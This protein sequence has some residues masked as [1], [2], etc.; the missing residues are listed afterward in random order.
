[1]IFTL[2]GCAPGERCLIERTEEG[3][4]THDDTVAANDWC[5]SDPAW[6]AR[7]GAD[8]LLSATFEQAEA[9]S[10]TR[11]EALARWS[12]RLPTSAFEW[13]AAPVLNP[14]TRVAVEMCPRAGTLRVVGYERAT[15]GELPAP[16]T[17]VCEIV[18]D[19]RQMMEEGLIEA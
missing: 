16:A 2:V 13:V 6:E 7:V 8:I 14:C 15:A 11:R 19:G 9:N 5:H 18:E 3:F 10:R 17:R 4:A 1:V 12:G